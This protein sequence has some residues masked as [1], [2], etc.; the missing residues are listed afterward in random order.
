MARIKQIPKKNV[1]FNEAVEKERVQKML[2]EH[3]WK[4]TY[5]MLRLIDIRNV[6][7]THGYVTADKSLS[8]IYNVYDVYEIF[9]LQNEI[10]AKSHILVGV[11]SRRYEN[12]RLDAYIL[13]GLQVREDVDMSYCSDISTNFCD[14]LCK[15]D[16]DIDIR[17]RHYHLVDGDECQLD[18][19][20]DIIHDMEDVAE[21]GKKRDVVF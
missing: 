2:N 14:V 16:N 11:Q 13:I 15:N 20:I 4:W 7:D 19:F 6:I 21:E 18:Y 8:R 10:G 9:D 12:D 3:K 1:G 17:H 5:C